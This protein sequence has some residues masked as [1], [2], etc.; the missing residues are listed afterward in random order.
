MPDLDVRI[1]AMYPP[2]VQGGIRAYASATIAGCFAVRGV[3][4]MESSRHY[5]E[6]LTQESKKRIERL[7]LITLPDKLSHGLMW[8][9]LILVLFILSH[10]L[11]IHHLSGLAARQRSRPAT[12]KLSR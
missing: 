2:G 1:T 12:L 4:V 6:S 10:V 7:A 3:K 9:A 8:V 5:I 11:T